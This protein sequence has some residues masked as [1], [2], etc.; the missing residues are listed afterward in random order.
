MYEKF[1][2]DIY[3]NINKHKEGN[4]LYFQ[5]PPPQAWSFEF[6]ALPQSIHIRKPSFFCRAALAMTRYLPP[7]D[8]FKQINQ[9][10]ERM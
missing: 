7:I 4:Y 1:A 5:A 8:D 6:L 2:F 9:E 3:F 10:R